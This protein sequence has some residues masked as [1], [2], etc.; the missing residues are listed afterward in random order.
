MTET[1]VIRP[2]TSESMRLDGGHPALDLVNTVY[3][4][5]DGPVEA[6]VLAIPED[7]VVFARR[8]GMA[9]RDTPASQAALRDVR[10]L[11]DALDALLR[12]RLAGHARPQAAITTIEACVRAALAAA[13]LSSQGGALAWTWPATDA[14]TPVHRFASAVS[15]LLTSEADLVRLRQC[16]ACRWLFLDHSR[17][18]GRRWCS[19]ADCGTEAKKRRYVQRR[20][21]RR[22]R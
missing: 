7:L 13:S 22:R 2:P 19:M 20:R 16:A 21:E 3:G 8:V 9:E 12:A 4:Q 10:A 15:D 11:R 5:V 18:A 14:H 17:G 1:P 6:D